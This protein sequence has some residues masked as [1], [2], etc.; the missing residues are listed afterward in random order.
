MEHMDEQDLLAAVSAALKSRED[1]DAIFGRWTLRLKLALRDDG[2][3]TGSDS[4]YSLYQRAGL[5]GG[6]FRFM[7]QRATRSFLFFP[8]AAKSPQT[9]ERERPAAGVVAN[10][11]LPRARR[12]HPI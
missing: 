5:P 10:V 7:L 2:G 4:K 6:S 8:A 11:Y 1:T 12:G 9:T 3:T